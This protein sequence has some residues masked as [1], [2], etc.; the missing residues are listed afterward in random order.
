[1]D[2]YIVA[3]IPYPSGPPHIGHWYNYAIVDS[4]CRLLKYN[5][6]KVY[7]P[8]AYDSFGLPTENAA[9]KEGV[10]PEIITRR[11]IMSFMREM[12]RMDTSYELKFAT[13]LKRYQERTQWLFNELLKAGL[14]YK[15]NR[16]EQFCEL[17]GTILA[18]EQI[19]HGGFKYSE[20][21]ERC[22][23]D[24]RYKEVNQWF[25][26]ITDYQEW[27]IE[28]L[29]DLDYPESTKKQ[30]LKWLLDLKDW[31]VGRQRKWGCP[32]PV[33]GETDT[34][35]TFVDSSF[36][37]IEYDKTRPVDLYVIGSE[38]AC[39][40]LI[41]ARF[42]T[43]FLYNIGY[44]DFK[45]PFKKV[46]HQGMIT[47]DGMKMSKSKGNVISPTEYDP[48][49][50]RMYLMFINHYFE[51]GSWSDQN[52]MGVVRFDKRM[53]KWF[54]ECEAIDVSISERE[55]WDNFEKLEK[56][57]K[58]NFEQW[59]TNKVISDW[60]TFYNRNKKHLIS[61]TLLPKIKE[62]YSIINPTILYAKT[63]ETPETEDITA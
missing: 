52:F 59:K 15:E 57:V 21:C 22:N 4:Y 39:A 26:R 7:S 8:W 42:I 61:S 31:S 10:S 3:A 33:E 12:R 11:N 55:L 23:T 62:F 48:G 45:E 46:I 50:L 51:G 47:K 32:I 17:C 6:E 35:D 25:F 34:L 40:H 2:K 60:M 41:Y 9:R 43:K 53:R 13:H 27:L 1:M 5:K 30:Q 63:Q 29:Y 38:H 20:K 58:N 44:I 54:D 14:A 18:R 28:D 37:T 16:S 24:I 49:Q 36:Y 56:S 19:I